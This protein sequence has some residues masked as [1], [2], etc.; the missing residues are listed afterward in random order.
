MGGSE[1][2]TQGEG[3]TPE[4]AFNAA[5]DEAAWEHGHGGYTGTIAEKGWFRE[6][7]LPDLPEG[8][9]V[10]A[11]AEACM[12]SA[13]EA[14]DEFRCNK[15]VDGKWESYTVPV[16]ES[17]RTVMKQIGEVAG[18]KYADAVCFKIKDDKYLFFGWASC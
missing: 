10:L 8:V 16:P 11:F 14:T 9:S 18:D 12:E 3:K 17:L 13:Y 2:F 1:F 5:R 7:P 15:K 4:A 6:F